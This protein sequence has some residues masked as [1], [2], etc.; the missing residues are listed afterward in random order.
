MLRYRAASTLFRR[1]SAAF[2]SFFSRDSSIWAFAFFGMLEVFCWGF[3]TEKPGGQSAFFASCYW[4]ARGD[5][6]SRVEMPEF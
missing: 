4:A 2:R 6:E 5:W 3:Y 1:L